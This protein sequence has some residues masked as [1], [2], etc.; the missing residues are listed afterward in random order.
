MSKELF[1]LPIIE[2]DDFPAPD[3]KLGTYPTHCCG[4]WPN[5]STHYQGNP[6]CIYVTCLICN[7][8]VAFRWRKW[9]DRIK[10]MFKRP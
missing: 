2:V 9:T 3:I 4:Q 10:W 8:I 5:I 7:K 6:S 1:G